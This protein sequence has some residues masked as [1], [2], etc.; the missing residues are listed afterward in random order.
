MSAET[1][2]ALIAAF[3]ALVVGY[4]QFVYRPR[5]DRNDAVDAK[6]DEVL[7]QVRNSHEKNLRD[8]IDE[9]FAMVHRRL[10]SQDADFRNLRDDFFDHVN[11]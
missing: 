9:K 4:W 2:A 5:S 3:A 8:D 11:K 6:L 10:D 1:L 7:H